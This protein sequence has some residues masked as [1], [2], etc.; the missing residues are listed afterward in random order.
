MNRL[1]SERDSVFGNK[2]YSYDSYGRISDVVLDGL[3][4][5]RAYN[6]YGQLK[7][8]NGA[9]YTYDEMGNRS[10]KAYRGRVTQYRYTRGNMLAGMGEETKYSY[11]V[12]GVRFRKEVNGVTTD[13]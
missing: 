6:E 1:I 5:T 8:F 11:N 4:K 2:T 12:E 10:R 13:Y 3:T 9:D 7:T